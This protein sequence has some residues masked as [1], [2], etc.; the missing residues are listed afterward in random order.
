[1]RSLSKAG[2]FAALDNAIE[3]VNAKDAELQ[4]ALERATEGVG[5]SVTQLPTHSR[6]RVYERV[7]HQLFQE[8][9]SLQVK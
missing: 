5:V 6:R 7:M 3:S 9:A 4:S 8:D 1:M 2:A